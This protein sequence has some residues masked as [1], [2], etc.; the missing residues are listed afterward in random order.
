MIKRLLVVVVLT[1]VVVLSA[2]TVFAEPRGKAHGK[3]GPKFDV[4]LIED[5]ISTSGASRGAP[6]FFGHLESAVC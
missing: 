5:I 6:G 3:G 4:A 1:I 2:I